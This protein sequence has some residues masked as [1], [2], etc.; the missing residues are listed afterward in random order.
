LSAPEAS[1]EIASTRIIAKIRT[2]TLVLSV[3][4]NVA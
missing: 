3:I 1:I 4:P 2:I